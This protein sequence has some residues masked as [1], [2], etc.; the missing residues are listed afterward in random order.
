MHLENLTKEQVLELNLD[1]GVPR[2]YELDKSLKIL[3]SKDLK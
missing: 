3:S 1:T 2:V